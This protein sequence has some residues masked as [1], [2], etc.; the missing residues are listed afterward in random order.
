MASKT[1]TVGPSVVEV[2][3]VMGRGFEVHV[4]YSGA[5]MAIMVGQSMRRR[6]CFQRL[7]Q[8]VWLHFLCSSKLTLEKKICLSE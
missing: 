2:E 5:H 1:W 3:L 7:N 4:A 6:N 8:C